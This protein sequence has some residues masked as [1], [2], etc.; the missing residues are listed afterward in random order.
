MIAKLRYDGD[1]VK[2]MMRKLVACH[3]YFC[4]LLLSSAPVQNGTDNAV[5][6]TSAIATEA[7]DENGN[8]D[9]DVGSHD[10]TLDSVTSEGT[11]LERQDVTV[12]DNVFV[13]DP[14]KTLS[15]SGVDKCSLRYHGNL[16]LW[17]HHGN[18]LVTPGR[19]FVFIFVQFMRRCFF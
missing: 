11:V 8:S 16:A 1:L 5:V 14:H 19:G 10:S 15:V 13:I 6:T 2:L 12:S 4:C 3:V 17:F 18:R 9:D 7:T